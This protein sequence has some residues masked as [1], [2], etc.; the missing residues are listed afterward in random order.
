MPWHAA[1]LL[2][3]LRHPMRAQLLASASAQARQTPAAAPL[4]QAAARSRRCP[5]TRAAAATAACT[6]LARK[7]A[8]R[9][10]RRSRRR[11]SERCGGAAAM[12]RCPLLGTRLPPPAF[13]FR[14]AIRDNS[15]PFVLLTACRHHPQ[16]SA[17]LLPCMHSRQARTQVTTSKAS[18]IHI[19]NDYYHTTLHTLMPRCCQHI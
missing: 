13:P 2:P 3:H 8:G 11:A 5:E 4:R 10:S 1:C 6:G 12:Q 15:S 17:I 9:R 16:S 18:F 7:A 14:S 19:K